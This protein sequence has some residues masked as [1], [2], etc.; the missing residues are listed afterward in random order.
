MI[1]VLLAM[2]GLADAQRYLAAHQLSEAQ[3]T[4]AAVLTDQPTSV[5][6]LLLQ[7]RIG[8][9]LGDPHLAEQSFLKAVENAKGAVQPRFLLG[10]F[11]YVEND[12]ARAL[13]ALQEAR[14]IA[15]NDSRTLLFL[16]LTLD[17]LARPA[18]AEALFQQVL[19]KP[20]L[21][22]HIA[23]ARM[24]FANGRYADAQR[25]VTAASGLGPAA[26]EVHYEQAR[27]SLEAGRFTEA[28]EHATKALGRPS[29]AVT[30]R[31]VH[32]LLS[33]AYLGLGD[34]VKAEQHRQS[35]EALAPRMVR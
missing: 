17:G 9:A 4:I 26:P 18:E 20:T 23:Y 33:R 28:I 10:F 13:P 3:Q 5:P 16:A 32:F 19:R 21:E 30:E 34:K 29:E 25:Q 12:F 15:P 27:L 11:Y 35:F 7:G 31:Q 2:S 8:M 14:R 1:P 24:L 22:A 6:A